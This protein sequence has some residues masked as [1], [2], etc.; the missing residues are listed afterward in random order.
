MTSTGR[1]LCH[2]VALVADGVIIPIV[3]LS[4]CS[5]LLELF[6]HKC[7]YVYIVLKFLWDDPRVI[8]SEKGACAMYCHTD[9]SYR[10]VGLQTL[11]H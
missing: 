6:F 10:S 4:P 3:S 7:V 9:R 5:G 1:L 8:F 2:G 11:A